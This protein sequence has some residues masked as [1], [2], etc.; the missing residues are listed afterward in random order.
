TVERLQVQ[1]KRGLL[2]WGIGWIPKEPIRFTPGCTHCD[3]RLSIIGLQ[4]FRGF[5]DKKVVHGTG[6]PGRR[7]PDASR[8]SNRKCRN[9]KSCPARECGPRNSIQLFP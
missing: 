1:D 2:R 9:G 5:F 7:K 4:I 3:E 6:P 8:T